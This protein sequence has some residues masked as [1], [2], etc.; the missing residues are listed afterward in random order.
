M[1]ITWKEVLLGSFQNLWFGVAGF[2]PVVVV[3]ILIILIG[4]VVAIFVG[5]AIARL[6]AVIKLDDVLRRANLEKVL[7]RGGFRLNSSAFIGGVVKWFIIIAFLIAAVDV[8]G[9]S[10][11]KGILTQLVVGFLPQVIIAAIILVAGAVFADIVS[12]LITGSATAAGV[13]SAR[14]IGTVSRWTIWIFAILMALVQLGI[15]TSL[16]QTLFTGVVVAVA[17]AF[18]LS[19]G[20]GGQQAAARFIEKT[21]EEISN[22]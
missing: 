5:S 3:A 13:K 12:R 1:L 16:I 9:L 2:V 21:R 14:F 4:W 7:A 6:V 17:L 10:Q 19:F 22:R 8:L 15:A 20:L 18:G 11:V